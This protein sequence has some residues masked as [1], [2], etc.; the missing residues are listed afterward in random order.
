MKSD[1]EM[2]I[3]E[4]F[5][6]QRKRGKQKELSIDSVKQIFHLNQTFSFSLDLS[7]LHYNMSYCNWS[8]NT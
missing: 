1:Q 4:T 7:Y 5:Y 2:K 8:S 3:K 6:I